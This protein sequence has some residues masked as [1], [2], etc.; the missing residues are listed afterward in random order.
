MEVSPAAEP[1]T[2]Y[3]LLTF[4]FFALAIIVYEEKLDILIPNLP[5]GSYRAAVG[6]VIFLI[7]A[8]ILA[9]FQIM[10]GGFVLYMTVRTLSHDNNRIR[11]WQALSLAS[12][13]T[14]LFSLTYAIFGSKGPLYYLVFV[15]GGPSWVLPVEILWTTFQIISFGYLLKRL[16]K[17]K[18]RWSLFTSA[19]ILILILDPAS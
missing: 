15:G 13:Q 3:K 10:S 7:P 17:L 16:T 2:K 19:F 1:L 6:P 8:I 12:I 5:G 11:M 18:W 9:G 4:L 14:F